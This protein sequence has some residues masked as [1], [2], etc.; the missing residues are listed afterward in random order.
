VNRQRVARLIARHRRGGRHCVCCPG[1]PV[2]EDTA[3]NSSS[4]LTGRRFAATRT[5]RALP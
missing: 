3:K 1:V 5:S 4:L 2:D